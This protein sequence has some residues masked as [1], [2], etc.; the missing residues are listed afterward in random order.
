MAP[1]QSDNRAEG[2]LPLHVA[3]HNTVNRYLTKIRQRLAEYYN[4]QS[5]YSGE[6]EVDELFFGA[7]RVK[8]KRGRGAYGKTIDFGIFKRNG[9]VY[10]EIVP[11]CSKA[12]LQAVIRGKVELESII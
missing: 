7:Q 2:R 5:H 3:R 4:A 6:V 11:D 9:H 12:M 8:G 1:S 10:T